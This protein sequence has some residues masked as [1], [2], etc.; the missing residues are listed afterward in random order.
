MRRGSAQLRLPMPPTARTGERRRAARRASTQRVPVGGRVNGS[1]R[2][3]SGLAYWSVEGDRRRASSSSPEPALRSDSFAIPKSS[4][5]TPSSAVTR[6]LDGFRVAVDDR[7]SHAQVRP[8]CMTIWRN[9][10]ARSRSSGRGSRTIVDRLA[11]HVLEREPG[12]TF[13]G[14]A[15]VV[16]RR[17]I[18]MVQRRH[19][20][21][22]APEA[23]DEVLALA[24]GWLNS[25]LIATWR[26]KCPVDAVG[27]PDLRHAAR[28]DMPGE[29]IRRRRG[30]PSH[31]AG[32]RSLASSASAGPRESLPFRP[33]A[34]APSMR[35]RSAIRCC[36]RLQSAP[37]RPELARVQDLR[38]LVQRRRALSNRRPDHAA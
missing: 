33:A 19:D 31:C 22:L 12:P 24:A 37:A 18:R 15:R 25:S 28:A 1:P 5:S 9:T 8:R 13:G 10:R 32:M 4:S 27:E 38:L 17:D 16:Q 7:A 29:P 11:A 23:L 6:T 20:V 36:D 2:I 30:C 3:C 14:H 35:S 26:S 21:A 34:R